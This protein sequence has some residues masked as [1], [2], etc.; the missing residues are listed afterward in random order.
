MSNVIMAS[1][2]ELK[3]QNLQSSKKVVTALHPR[4]RFKSYIQAIGK[5]H[6][7]GR[8]LTL[9]E[10][11]DAMQ[12]LLNN[13]VSAEQ[14]G[15]FLMLL[16]V[17]EETPEE[18]AGFLIATRK[19]NITQNMI[20]N[21][22]LD[23]ACY[24][25]KRRHLPWLI[26]AVMCLAQR[27]KRIFL[28]GTD[29]PDT[30]RL[31][32]SEVLKNLGFIPTSCNVDSQAMMNQYGFAYGDLQ[33]INPGL[34]HLIQLRSQFG[35]RSCANTLA[36]MLNPYS[37]KA[38]LQGVYHRNLDAKHA[39]V[40]QILNEQKVVC[41]RGDS[42]EVEYNPERDLEVLCVEHGKLSIAH[43]DALNPQWV[44]KPRVL[45]PHHLKTVWHGEQ[46]D[47]YGESA[48]IGTLSLMIMATEQLPWQD[49]LEIA[50]TYWK[51][52]DLSGGFA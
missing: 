9:N 31:Y 37:A 17:R 28:H 23:M 27:G 15:A 16:R 38:S 42:G 21:I 11:S 52:R 7:S 47:K 35:L 43:V 41:F 1:A 34:H 18:I 36:R 40:A 4:E 45:N 33:S 12:L 20:S 29:E 46:R 14:R 25:G 32:V 6:R 5:G 39:K 48:I 8:P 2:S 30:Q 10:A 22:D 19:H 49:A 3:Q 44:T 51:Q 26:L 24:A 13:E 50:K